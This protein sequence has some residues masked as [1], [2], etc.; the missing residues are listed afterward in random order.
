MFQI[1]ICAI[2]NK[3]KNICQQKSENKCDLSADL[4]IDYQINDSMTQ[5]ESD[6][7]KSDPKFGIETLL[8]SQ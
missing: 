1:Y 6:F 8:F 7:E 4:G 2:C 3:N 5:F